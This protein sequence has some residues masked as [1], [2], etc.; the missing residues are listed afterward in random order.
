MARSSRSRQPH[1]CASTHEDI[2]ATLV[3]ARIVGGTKDLACRI[4]GA[5]VRTQ[6]A[7]ALID[8]LR[9]AGYPGYAAACNTSEEVRQRMQH[10]YGDKYG[11]GLFVPDSVRAAAELAHRAKL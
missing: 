1:K 10:M 8:A 5:T 7:L 4:E 6:V 9:S 3:N 11:D 2:L